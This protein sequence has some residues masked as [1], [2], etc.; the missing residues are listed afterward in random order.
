[1]QTAQQVHD[2]IL[3][4]FPRVKF[5]CKANSWWCRL[6]GRFAPA[7][8]TSFATTLGD[9]I[10]YP[11]ELSAATLRHERVHLRQQRRY[12]MI[13]YVL[14]YVCFP[15]PVMLAWGRWRLEREAYLE[16]LQAHR[17]DCD[18]AS[19][20]FMRGAQIQRIVDLLADGAYLWAWPFRG[21]MTKYFEKNSV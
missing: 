21:S 18:A 5:V 8:M 17:D 14:M 20:Q 10:Y 13:L 12:G 2:D 3:R 4:E 6:V 7:F 9:T 11:H 15:L 16:S 19:W 1:M